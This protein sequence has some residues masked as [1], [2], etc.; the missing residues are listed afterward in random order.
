[1]LQSFRQ[2]MKSNNNQVLTEKQSEIEHLK[3]QLSQAE[4]QLS[5]LKL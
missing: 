5:E 4:T 3:I 2:E 1:M